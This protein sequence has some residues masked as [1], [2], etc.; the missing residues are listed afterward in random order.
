MTHYM[1]TEEALNC[2]RIRAMRNKKRRQKELMTHIVMLAAVIF[3][4]A[5]IATLLISKFEASAET[6]SS[7]TKE[8][9]CVMV[10]YGENLYDIAGHFEDPVYYADKTALINEIKRI[11]H[12]SDASKVTP[13]DYII[14]P[15]YVRQDM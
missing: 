10:G 4:A 13:G 8:Y 5:V 15:Y 12:I 7:D 6:T 3:C 14:V 1:N 2:Y 9:T 11:N